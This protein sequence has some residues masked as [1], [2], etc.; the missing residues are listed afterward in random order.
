MEKIITAVFTLSVLLGIF[1][2]GY[3][4]IEPHRCEPVSISLPNNSINEIS[5]EGD[6]TRRLYIVEDSLSGIVW[7]GIAG[8]NIINK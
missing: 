7:V 3:S 1:L 2:I 5:F 6:T 8:K 4:I